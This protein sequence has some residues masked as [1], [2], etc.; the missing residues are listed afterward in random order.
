MVN[1]VGSIP[2]VDWN[3]GEF[4]LISKFQG[5]GI[6]REV[7]EMVFTQF[8]GTWEVSQIPEN[9]GAVVFWEKVVDRYAKGCL[10]K[11]LK[12]IPEPKPHPMIVI[13]FHT[14][15]EEA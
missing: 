4:F 10:Q 14:K 7:A 5:K 1:Q 2:E 6:G 3:M 8:P 15:K 9:A 12:T 11:E 13:R